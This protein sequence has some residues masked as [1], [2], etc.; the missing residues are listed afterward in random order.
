MA[1]RQEGR[2][3][4]SAIDYDR[5]ST[6]VVCG[7]WR[8]IETA[9]KR[10]PVRVLQATSPKH[11]R[12]CEAIFTGRAWFPYPINGQPELRPQ[13]IQWSPLTSVCAAGLPLKASDAVC[14]HCGATDNDDCRQYPIVLQAMLRSAMCFIHSVR[15]IDPPAARSLLEE[16]DKLMPPGTLAGIE[17]PSPPIDEA[18]R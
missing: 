7:N 18:N 17:N 6:V 14:P 4:T 8:P 11:V 2:V 16:A 5:M 10:T 1:C 12:M 9:P 15:N 13:P 3:K